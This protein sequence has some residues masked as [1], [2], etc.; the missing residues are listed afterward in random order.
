MRLQLE[1]GRRAFLKASTAE[2]NEIMRTGLRTEEQVYREL[3][4]TVLKEWAPT[5]LGAFIEGD[6]HCLLLEDLGPASVPP[7]TAAKARQIAEEYG[8]FH[9]STLGVDLPDWLRRSD[10]AGLARGWDSLVEEP[11]NLDGLNAARSGAGY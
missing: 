6:W 11:A 10:H 9:A 1:D 5:L 3:G 8:R 7:W 2:S 4:E